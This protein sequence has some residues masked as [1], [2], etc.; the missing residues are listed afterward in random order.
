MWVKI[1]VIFLVVGMIALSMGSLGLKVALAEDADEYKAP[2]A[3]LKV[4]PSSKHSLADGIKQA[5]QGV[6]APISAKFELD[7]K[8]KL[9][10]SVY[11]AQKGLNVDSQ[12]NV[13][14]EVSGSPESSAWSPESEVIKD[15][16]DLKSAQEQLTVLSK[17]KVS[18]LDIVEKATKEHQGIAF[19]AMPENED[20]KSVCK[21]IIA[22]D[23][24]VSE[25]HYDVASGNEVKEGKMD[26]DDENKY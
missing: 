7:E 5:T 10:L 13:F 9:S 18:L 16:G 11:I 1:R 15:Q 20:N 2:D 12:N 8:G 21:V 26:G 22:K 25:Y 24:K 14:K 23:G 17:G 3:L 4:L 19:A 6:E